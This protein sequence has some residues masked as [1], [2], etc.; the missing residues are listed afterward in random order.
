MNRNP[1]SLA[2]AAALLAAAATAT[3]AVAQDKPS[4]ATAPRLKLI[5]VER[6]RFEAWDNAVSLDDAAGDAMAYTRNRTTLG[7]DWKP[8]KNLEVLGKVTNEFRVYLAPKDRPFGWHELFVDNLFVKWTLPGRVPFTVTAGRQDINLGE[9]FVVA[10]GTPGDGS[11]SYY[12]NALRVDAGLAKGHT[13]TA[14][15]HATKGTDRYLPVVHPKP[16]ALAEQPEAALALYYAVTFGKAKVDA[17]AVRKTTEAT[18]AW[19]V[20]TRTETFGARAVAALAKPLALTA[21]AALQ[22]GRSG[23]AGRSAYGAI[24]HLDWDLAGGLPLLKSFVL[25]GILLSGDDP[26]TARAEG[27]DPIFSRWPKWSESF[28]YTYTRESRPSFWSNLRAVYAQLAFDFGARSDGHIMV[29]PMGAGRAAAA[30]EFPGGTGRTRGTLVRGRLNYKV[31]KYLTGRFIWERFRPGSFYFAGASS[32][33][34][35]QFEMIFRY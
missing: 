30:G 16:Q 17:Y 34:W 15:A 28:I 19:P 9:G 6:F 26:A 5:F 8:I 20:P 27:W 24:S 4:A 11:R 31:S 13:L 25:G 33:N 32:Y 22:T 12:F 7:L 23:S 35:L 10:D 18:E 29:M 1:L 3:P 2:I 14:F 21:E